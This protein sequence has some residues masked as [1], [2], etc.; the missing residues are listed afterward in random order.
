MGG[1]ERV[2]GT[3]KSLDDE[4]VDVAPEGPDQKAARWIVAEYC[5]GLSAQE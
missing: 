4:D 2:I 1:P 5:Y 3:G